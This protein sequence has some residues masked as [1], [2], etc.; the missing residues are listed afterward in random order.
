MASTTGRVIPIR[1]EAYRCK[2]TC[3][4]FEITVSHDQFPETPLH[5]KDVGESS[6]RMRSELYPREVDGPAGHC[7]CGA[8]EIRISQGKGCDLGIERTDEEDTC[9]ERIGKFLATTTRLSVE[10][11][12]SVHA[13]P[14]VL[15]LDIRV[16]SDDILPALCLSVFDDLLLLLEGASGGRVGDGESVYCL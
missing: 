7:K 16:A 3:Q 4:F 11:V 6:S 5:G 1:I 14:G 9:D 10:G 2:S 8:L 12:Y 13:P 15:V